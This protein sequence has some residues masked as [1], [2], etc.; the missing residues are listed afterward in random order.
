[1]EKR[2]L[3]EGDVLQLNP[4]HNRFPGFLVVCT[5]PKSFG[6]MGYLM[7][8]F[9]FEACRFKGVAYIRVKFE[10]VEFVGKLPWIWLR[11]KEEEK[12]RNG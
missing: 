8:Q 12:D 9:E 4:E 3:E 11:I 1:M 6:C 10:D 5:D 2:E 7:S